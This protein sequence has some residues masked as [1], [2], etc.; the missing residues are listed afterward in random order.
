MALALRMG[1]YALFAALGG[2]EFATFNEASGDLTI[3]AESVIELLIYAG[4]FVATF[5]G[6]R[7]AKARGGKT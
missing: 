5:L 3:H 2:Y 6:S 7:W 1:L 4:G